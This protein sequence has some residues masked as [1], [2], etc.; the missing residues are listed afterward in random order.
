MIA[1]L[2]PLSPGHSFEDFIRLS[3]GTFTVV[4]RDAGTS[5]DVDSGLDVATHDSVDFSRF[6]RCS[7][8][9]IAIITWYF[10]V[11]LTYLVTCG[12]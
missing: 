4:D 11:S 8:H 6:W 1:Q 10:R 3:I 7:R 2:D 9:F 12:H 5:F